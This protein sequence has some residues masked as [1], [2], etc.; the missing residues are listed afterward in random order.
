MRLKQ[1]A[2]LHNDSK[3]SS[4]NFQIKLHYK[5]HSSGKSS[6]RGGGNHHQT[7]ASSGI[8]IAK[9]NLCDLASSEKATAQEQIDARHLVDLTKLTKSVQTVEKVIEAIQSGEMINQVV[10]E[11]KLTRILADS[12]KGPKMLITTVNPV[13]NETNAES[14]EKDETIKTL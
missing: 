12:F 9:F 2:N 14:V 3:R 8:H 13:L 4:S 6:N 11:S 1:L 5:T 10:K 7:T